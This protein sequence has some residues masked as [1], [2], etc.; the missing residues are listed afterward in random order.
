MPAIRERLVDVPLESLPYVDEHR[1]DVAAPAD[2]VWEALAR[3]VG[4]TGANPIGRRIAGALRCV[5]AERRGRI[6]EIGATIPGFIVTRSVAPAVLALMGEHRFARY[7]LIFRITETASGP[8][9]LSAESRAEFR[10]RRGRVYRALVIGTRGHV[11]AT[12]SILRSVRR[13]AE[14][15]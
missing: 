6:P 13:T 1:V 12:H 5:P 8:V 9:R 11:L 3:R 15:A 7:A 10:G 2:R 14:R 4:G